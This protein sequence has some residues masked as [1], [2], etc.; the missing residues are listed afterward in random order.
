[1]SAINYELKNMS[2]NFVAN[3][4]IARKENRL[5]FREMGRAIGVSDSTI[6]R[7]ETARKTRFGRGEQGY[8]PT[9]RTVVKMANAL[10]VKPAELLMGRL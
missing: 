2:R 9:L 6:R 3:A 4:N 8:V 7:I 5:S 10:E 1:M